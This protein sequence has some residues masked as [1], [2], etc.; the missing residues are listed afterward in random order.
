MFKLTHPGFHAHSWLDVEYWHGISWHE[1][2]EILLN[3]IGLPWLFNECD[4]LF[5]VI[6]FG[7][8][9]QANTL[10]PQRPPPSSSMALHSLSK[11]PV[12]VNNFVA[13]HLLC[14]N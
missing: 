12:P 6:D 2:Y 7:T 13:C 4:A 8:F 10:I 11:T 1:R 9:S 3:S 14:P 5:V